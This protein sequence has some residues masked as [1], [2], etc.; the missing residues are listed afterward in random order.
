MFFVLSF[1][2][3]TKDFHSPLVQVVPDMRTLYI[4]KVHKQKCSGLVLLQFLKEDAR[5]AAE[6][7]ASVDMSLM[8]MQIE[9]CW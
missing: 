5:L 3:L 4:T 8:K 2:Y 6:L 1:C 9:K 7:S